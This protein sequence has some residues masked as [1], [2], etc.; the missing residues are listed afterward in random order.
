MYNTGARVSEIIGIR[1]CDVVLEAS[2]R[3][4]AWQGA[5]A[6]MRSLVASDSRPCP[7]LA[8]IAG[9]NRAG[10]LP[11]AKPHRRE[12]DPRQSHA[13]AG[14]G[15]RRSMATSSL[16]RGPLDL[17]PC[18]PAHDGNAS[19]SVRHR[20][21]LI[22]LWLGHEGTATTHMYVEVDLSMMNRPWGSGPQEAR[23]DGKR[24]FPRTFCD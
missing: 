17:V 14:S 4:P 6:A 8:A 23:L 22:A 3:A 9:G 2:R 15:R 24:E 5:Q 13:T 1:C 19:A 7:A 18:D 12:V 11:A 21:H 10:R 16:S 20:Y